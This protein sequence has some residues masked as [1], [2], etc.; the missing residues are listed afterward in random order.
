MNDQVIGAAIVAAFWALFP[1]FSPAV[2]K[3]IARGCARCANGWG[4][5]KQHVS[6]LANRLRTLR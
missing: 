1:L 2:D 3:L 5:T 6:R 4:R